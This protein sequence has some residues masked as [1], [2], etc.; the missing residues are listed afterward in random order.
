MLEVF[1]VFVFGMR[2]LLT[3]VFIYEEN[4]PLIFLW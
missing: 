4:L 2:Y 1:A 3:L